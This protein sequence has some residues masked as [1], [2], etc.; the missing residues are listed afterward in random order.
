MA[1]DTRLERTNCQVS[2][3]ARVCSHRVACLCRDSQGAKHAPTRASRTMRQS[4]AFC[5]GELKP[6]AQRH[7]KV[8]SYRNHT[9]NNKQ[10]KPAPQVTPS[11]KPTNRESQNRE[12]LRVDCVTRTQFGPNSLDC[13]SA[14]GPKH[15]AHTLL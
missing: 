2:T 10:P 5:A 3:R 7:T 6:R 4:S 14:S 9:S 13:V 1:P 15:W 12:S 11:E 8:V